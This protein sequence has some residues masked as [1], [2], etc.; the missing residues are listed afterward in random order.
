[1]KTKL[2]KLSLQKAYTEAWDKDKTSIHVM[3]DAMDILLA[4]ANKV[5]YSVVSTS[6]TF[7]I[8]LSCHS[9]WKNIFHNKQPFLRRCL[10]VFWFVF[11]F[12]QKTYKQANE[13]AK[14]KGYDLRNDAISIIAA[15]ASRDIASDVRWFNIYYSK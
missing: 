2:N 14:K 3:P 10:K 9:F 5:N 12:T 11:S 15:R 1:M 8:K 13:D 6:Q 7:S 4:K